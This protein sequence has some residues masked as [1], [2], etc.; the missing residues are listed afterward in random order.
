MRQILWVNEMEQKIIGRTYNIETF[1]KNTAIMKCSKEVKDALK[2]LKEGE[3]TL[4]FK[5]VG[6]YF[7]FIEVNYDETLRKMVFADFQKNDKLAIGAFSTTHKPTDKNAKAV[8]DNFFEALTIYN[9]TYDKHYYDV[10][11]KKDIVV[12]N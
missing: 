8:T 2:N 11:L 7:C 10:E 9:K 5:V 1:N 3:G 4:V 6:R 12:L